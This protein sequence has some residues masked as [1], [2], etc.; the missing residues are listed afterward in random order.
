MDIHQAAWGI[1]THIWWL[2]FDHDQAINDT[3]ATGIF[4][5]HSSG[6]NVGLADGSVRFLSDTMA[7]ETLNALV[8]RSAGDD[9]TAE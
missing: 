8:T 5:F 7:Q 3:N 4:S 1:S 9:A 6:T 2:V